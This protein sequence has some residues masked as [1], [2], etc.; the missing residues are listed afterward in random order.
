MLSPF[1]RVGFTL[2]EL[3]VVI[4]IIA[5]LIGLL[6]P[7]VQKVRESAARTKCQNNLKQIGL[8]AHNY[9][10]TYGYFPPQYGWA[11]GTAGTGTFGPLLYHLLPFVEQGPLFAQT[12]YTGPTGDPGGYMSP[13]TKYNGTYDIRSSGIEGIQP[14]IFRCP[15]DASFD[16]MSPTYG[17]GASSYGGNFQ[18]FGNAATAPVTSVQ[19]GNVAWQGVARL[20]MSIPDGTSNTLM[21]I[22]RMAQCNPVA[23]SA[24]LN[25]W[26][27]WDYTDHQSTFAA[28]TTGPGSKFQTVTAWRTSACNGILPNSPHANATNACLVDGSVRTLTIAISGNTWWAAC[29]PAAGDLL[30][31]E[32]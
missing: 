19:N 20:Q 21:F 32:W 10:D 18:L 3:L 27:R 28:Y 30:G 11:G 25:M 24:S 13:Y 15:S 23:T 6:L 7:A 22:D 26:T 17:W 4:A 14:Q 12:R 31:Q 5:V 2:I 29:T 8:A 1:K 16:S 9:H